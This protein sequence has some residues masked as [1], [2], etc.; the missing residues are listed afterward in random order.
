MTL[1][2]ATPIV[3]DPV[4]RVFIHEVKGHPQLGSTSAFSRDPRVVKAP[5]FLAHALVLRSMG[6]IRKQDLCA[7]MDDVVRAGVDTA[8]L[9]T[10]AR[11]R[12]GVPD[13]IL[14]ELASGGR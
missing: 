3:P 2:D 7:V 11:D 10:D 5:S 12:L 8:P 13:K 4:T 9:L 1:A 6:R 14:G